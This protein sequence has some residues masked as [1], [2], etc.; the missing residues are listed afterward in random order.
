MFDYG[1]AF[2]LALQPDGKIVVAGILLAVNNQFTLLRLDPG[3]ALDASFG[4]A[5]KVVVDFGDG[6]NSAYAVAVLSNG[7]IVA[8]GGWTHFSIARVLPDGS[9][10]P[11]F[12]SGGKVLTAVSALPYNTAGALALQPDG[13]IVCAGWANTGKYDFAVVRYLGD[14]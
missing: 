6:N 2:G 11:N 12:G 14:E 13:K 4:V 9:L 10:D 8:A 3:G 7:K 1:S 5:G